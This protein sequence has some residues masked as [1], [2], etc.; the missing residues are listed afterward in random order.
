MVTRAED[1]AAFVGA[2][3]GEIILDKKTSHGIYSKRFNLL[4]IPIIKWIV[5]QRF[6]PLIF[7][8]LNLV[9]FSIVIFAGFFGT[10]VGNANI[11]IVFVWI[12]WWSL[13]MLLLV[14]GMGRFWCTICPIPAIGEWVQRG[15]IVSKSKNKKLHGKRKGFPKK[16]KNMWLASFGFLG[17]AIF[18]GLITTIPLATGIMLLG[19]I[20]VAI[21]SSLYFNKRAFCRYICPVSGF[22]GLY[23]QTGGLEVRIKDPEVCKNHK[24]KYCFNG[25]EKGYGCPWM[26]SNKNGSTP[27]EVNTPCGMCME[28]VKTCSEDNIA[29]NIRAPGADLI[30]PGHRTID[31]AFKAFIMLGAALLYSSVLLGS[32]GDLKQM[33]NFHDIFGMILY[34][35]FFLTTLLVIIPSI[36]WVSSI[37]THHLISEKEITKKEIFTN[38][39]YAN[40]PLGLMTWIG[41]SLLIILPNWVYIVNVINDP[42][43][44]GWHLLGINALAWHPVFTDILPIALALTI[45]VGLLLSIRLTRTIAGQIFTNPKDLFMSF[46]VQTIFLTMFTFVVLLAFVG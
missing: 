43:G 38:F 34:A 20:T 24:T 22:I 26:S 12:L 5:N 8:A 2:H 4:S 17:I 23:S 36:F 33:A 44:F 32:N 14:P 1:G 35:G 7:V 9:V 29:F 19:L 27:P 6:Y 40:I 42:F 16:L 25:N 41:F 45:L 13:L 30:K 28:C 11:A 21:I 46:S 31:E 10:P 18:S 39:A 37:I 15:A 3:K